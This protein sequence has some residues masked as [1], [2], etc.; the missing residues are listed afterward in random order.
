MGGQ[1]HLRLEVGGFV[2]ELEK[3][4]EAGSQELLKLVLKE[5]NVVNERAKSAYRAQLQHINIR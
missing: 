4:V 3:E 5:V 1:V 2:Q